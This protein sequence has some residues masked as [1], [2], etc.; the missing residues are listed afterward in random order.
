MTIDIHFYHKGHFYIKHI[1]F[2]IL[3]SVLV[4]MYKFQHID[5]CMDITIEWLKFGRHT[6]YA[7]LKPGRWPF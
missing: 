3:P 5:P 1:G 4:R 6:I 7:F 2:A